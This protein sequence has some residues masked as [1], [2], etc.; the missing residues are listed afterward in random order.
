MEVASTL[1]IQELHAS[2][3][4]VDVWLEKMVKY[5]H[6][7]DKCVFSTYTKI[8]LCKLTL[9]KYE[10]ENHSFDKCVFRYVYIH[11]MLCKGSV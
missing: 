5:W 11:K 10:Y 7:F 9:A 4:M 6:G 1:G 8:M 2:N 3:S